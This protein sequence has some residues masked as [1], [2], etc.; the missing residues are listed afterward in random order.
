MNPYS[1]KYIIKQLK[2][3]SFPFPC[4]FIYFDEETDTETPEINGH[5][6]Y[7]EILITPMVCDILTKVYKTQIYF[8]IPDD[9]P[10]STP[11]VMLEDA[12]IHPLV[13]CEKINMCD[14]GV[15]IT[16]P[17]IIVNVYCIILEGLYDKENKDLVEYLNFIY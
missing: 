15:A 3:V 11:T 7:A 17:Q 2:D 8:W 10:F 1:K 4:K 9:Y 6:I 5:V 16:F 14:Y 13:N 12:I